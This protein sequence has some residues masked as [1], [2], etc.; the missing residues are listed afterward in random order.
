MHC[1]HK[2]A[3]RILRHGRLGE[4]I[5]DIFLSLRVCAWGDIFRS[6]CLRGCCQEMLRR[7]WPEPRRDSK[8]GTDGGV[9]EERGGR[10]PPTNSF[11]EASATVGLNVTSSL[12]LTREEHAKVHFYDQRNHLWYLIGFDSHSCSGAADQAL[13]VHR[14]TIGPITGSDSVCWQD[15]SHTFTC[16]VS[17]LSN[18]AWTLCINC[19]MW[20]HTKIH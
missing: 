3:K 11:R 14:S 8:L 13:P 20:W 6:S 5:T 17:A 2:L 18:E 10:L 16:S 7:R 1:Y 9:P 4:Q 15:S 19:R 12:F